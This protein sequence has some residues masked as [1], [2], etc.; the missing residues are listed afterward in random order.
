MIL[1]RERYLSDL[2][3]LLAELEVPESCSFSASLLR[4]ACQRTYNQMASNHLST[5]A[6]I[7]A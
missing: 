1:E 5:Y 2:F 4:A 7:F 3:E 6:V